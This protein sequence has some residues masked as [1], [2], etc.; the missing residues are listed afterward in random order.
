MDAINSF[1]EKLNLFELVPDLTKLAGLMKTIATVCMLLG[2]VIMLILGLIYYFY[3]PKEANRKFGFRTYFGMGSVEAWRF[4]QKIAGMV[5]GIL[6]LLLTVIMAVLCLRFKNQDAMTMMSTAG[7]SLIAQ[8]V[9]LIA[10]YIGV[11]V[12]SAVF[13]DKNGNR[14]R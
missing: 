7:K 1:I 11:S 5:F 2:P 9:L 12:T 6:G 13:F 14:K 8:L 4:T 10:A 3:P